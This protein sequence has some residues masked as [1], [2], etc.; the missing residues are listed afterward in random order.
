MIKMGKAP[1]RMLAI[2]AVEFTPAPSK[3]SGAKAPGNVSACGMRSSAA[4]TKPVARTTKARDL[5]T[6]ACANRSV[7]VMSSPTSMIASITGM[8][9]GTSVNR[10]SRT[11]RTAK[12]SAKSSPTATRPTRIS[13]R[14]GGVSNSPKRSSDTCSPLKATYL[15]GDRNQASLLA[16]GSE[17]TAGSGTGGYPQFYLAVSSQF[18]ARSVRFPPIA[19]I[20]RVSAFDP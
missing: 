20:S 9:A 16:S 15:N 6:P 11:G 4:P 12:R 14:S 3:P 8:N 13:P 2:Q 1:R 18:D 5:N 10:I 19:D 17:E 7:A